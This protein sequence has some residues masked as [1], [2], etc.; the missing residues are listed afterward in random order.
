MAGSRP[1]GGGWQMGGGP[2]LRVWAGWLGLAWGQHKQR[3]GRQWS[4]GTNSRHQR[5]WLRKAHYNIPSKPSLSP[6]KHP[7]HPPCRISLTSSTQKPVDWQYHGQYRLLVSAVQMG[8]QGSTIRAGSQRQPRPGSAA[9]AAGS[10]THST[11]Q[12]SQSP[13]LRP[14]PGVPPH[15]ATVRLLRAPVKAPMGNSMMAARR[16]MTATP[17]TKRCRG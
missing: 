5:A 13:A 7:A 10:Y 4:P 12:P 8:R 2:V 9:A 11:V 3:R 14:A 15:T 1:A 17:R 6:A 16:G